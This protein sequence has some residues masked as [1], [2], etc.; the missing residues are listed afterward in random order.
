M[1]RVGVAAR[2]HIEG[3]VHVD[4][5]VRGKQ[6]VHDRQRARLDAE[7]RTQR[8]GQGSAGVVA[9][10]DL[11]HNL[12]EELLERLDELPRPRV[13]HR[14]L[15]LLTA[16]RRRVAGRASTGGP[17]REEATTLRHGSGR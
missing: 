6:L 17:V 15:A 14:W 3:D 11:V 5:L 7:M 2:N 13:K 1:R 4:E 12:L 16:V 9:A 10:P 8:L